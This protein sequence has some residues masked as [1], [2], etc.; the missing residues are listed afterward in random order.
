MKMFRLLAATA[1]IIPSAPG[2]AGTPQS[3]RWGDSF[4]IVFGGM[5]FCYFETRGQCEYS[6]AQEAKAFRDEGLT[7]DQCQP[8]DDPLSLGADWEFFATFF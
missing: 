4:C 2:I 5:E 6:R 8:S 3:P 1:L 7:V